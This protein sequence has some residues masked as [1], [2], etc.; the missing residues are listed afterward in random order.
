[1]KKT[2]KKILG[3]LGLGFVAAT[4]AVAATLPTPLASA[5]TSAVDTLMVYV[6][7]NEPELSMTS[8]S[9]SVIT[10]PNYSFKVGY[11]NVTNVKITLVNKTDAGEITH[12]EVIWN[13][14]VGARGEKVFDLDLNNYGGYGNFTITGVALGNGDVPIERI[15]TVKYTQQDEDTSDEGDKQPEVPV[16]IPEEAVVSVTFNLYDQNRQTLLKTLN[17]ENPS[18]SEELDLSELPDGIYWLE[19]V[20]KNQNGDVLSTK[21]ERIVIDKDGQGEDLP[22]VIEDVGEEISKVT[23]AVTNANG[24]TITGK[25]VMNPNPGD[26]VNID[27]PDNL[28]AGIYTITTKYYDANDRVIKTVIEHFIKSDTGGYIIVPVEPTIDSVTTIETE[29]YNDKNEVVRVLKADRATGVVDVYDANGHL[30]FSVP[31]GYNDDYRKMVISMEGL[32][33]GEYLSIISYKNQYGHL[34]GNTRR[35]KIRW[36][37]DK[38][39]IVPDTGGFFQG[40]NI[41]REDYLI[42]GAVVFMIIGVVAFGVVKRNRSSKK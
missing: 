14:D 32:P 28:P 12:T 11:D 34:V 33:A 29:I 36:S 1:M 25:T 26:V 16:D 2:H 13:Q 35:V 31:N 21:W 10:N 27:L 22:I 18:S 39:I 30:L 20:S 3:S 4:T 24:D 23:I 42:T 38:G 5:V 40:L 37:G 9:Q 41:S 8:D 15:L 17:K 6:D 19:T 7:H